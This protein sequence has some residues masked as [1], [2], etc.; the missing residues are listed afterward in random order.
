[1][2]ARRRAARAHDHA[3]ALV[4]DF[5]RARGRCRGS[6]DPWRHGSRR[7]R[8]RESA[9]RGD[10][11]SRS[12]RASARHAPGSGSRVRRISRR[13]TMPDR[14][15]AQAGEHFLRVVADRRDDPHAGD[16]DTS[17]RRS[18]HCPPSM[19]AINIGG[20]AVQAQPAG[21]RGLEQADAQI[22][23]L[24]DA[25]AVGLQPAVGDAEH[26]LALEDA[27]D[28][29]AVDDELDRRQHLVGEFDLADAERPAAARTGRASRGRTRS[30]CHSASRPRQPGMTGSPLKWQPKNQSSGLMS[31]SART[32]PLPFAPPASEI[33]VMRSNISIGGS[34]NCALPA[35]N[36]SPAPAGEQLF[37]SR[38][39]IASRSSTPSPEPSQA[40]AARRSFGAS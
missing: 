23:G 27:L 15:F 29:D 35:P 22:L 25:L 31:N 36:N 12:G 7:C 4:G 34:G 21:A 38:N 5:V 20:I 8:R 13:V 37:V 18:P 2:A 17:H 30:I 32:S 40:R 6:P 3:G 10:R 26:E 9:S 28:V 39:W 11:P 24:I 14:A 1:M 16:D 19:S 33:S